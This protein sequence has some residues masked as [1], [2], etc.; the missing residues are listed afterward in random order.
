MRK[1][2]CMAMVCLLVL[3]SLCVSAGAANTTAFSLCTES[4]QVSGAAVRASGSFNI[5]VAPYG[6]SEANSSFP[7]QA[8]ET[9]SISAVY[10]PE[11]ASMD[12]G[13]IDPNG[14]FRYFNET[15]GN[16]D[17]TIRVSV[18]GNYTFAVRNNSGTTVRVSGF[19]NY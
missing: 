17:K 10:T 9:V 1:I 4:G 11:D 13:L 3:S 12:F 2:V 8:G 16:V 6:R 14:V 19:V 7:L 15:D 18:A 5:S